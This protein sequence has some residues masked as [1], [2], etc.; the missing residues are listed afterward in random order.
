V[1]PLK[2]IV[3]EM[4]PALER[5][6]EW[7]APSG[8]T[9]WLGVLGI[10]LPEI[11]NRLGFPLRHYDEDGLGPT[12]DLLLRLPTG[13]VVVLQEVEGE[14]MTGACRGPNLWVDVGDIVRLGGADIRAEFLRALNLGPEAMEFV[15]PAEHEALAYEA[16]AKAQRLL[17]E[18]ARRPERGGNQGAT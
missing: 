5:L 3:T 18:R 2:E 17:A 4:T 11:A 14:V 1:A 15:P 9:F 7:R 16:L 10:R 13:T 8:D 6:S 12:A